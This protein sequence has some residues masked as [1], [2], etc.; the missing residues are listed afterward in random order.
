MREPSFEGAISFAQDLIRIPSPP[1]GEGEVAV[2]VKAEMEALGYAHVRVDEVGNVIGSVEGEGLAPAILVNAHLDVVAEGDPEEW[3]YPPFSGEIAG[4]C[5]HG[6]GSMDIKGQLALMTHAAASLR[7]R[8]SGQVIMAHTVLE[9]RGGWGM[10]HLLQEGSV[11]PGAV[12]IGEATHGDVT[13]G[14]RGR[15]ELEVVVRGVSGHA[16]A[17]ERARNPIDLLPPLLA[18]VGSLAERQAADPVLGRASL[19]PTGLE[20]RPESRNVIP[21]ELVLVLDWRILPNDT[22]ETLTERLRDEI[23]VA[24]GPLPDGLRIEV[25]AAREHQRTYTGLASHRS[26][27]TPGF[28]MD[29]G[30]PVVQAAAR[31]AGKKTGAGPATARPW[32]FATDGGWSCGVFGI[33]TVGFAPGEEGFAHTNRERLDL[34]EARWAYDRYPGIISAMQSALA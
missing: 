23:A 11:S 9:E 3:E 12:L 10:E 28:L 17:P 7:G 15:A 6:R 32:R 4:G 29:T 1:G 18:A 16:S 26:I 34:E 19:A 22:E 8:A 27:I 14:H 24:V 31:A 20:V 30:H 21:D 5:L 33:P 2:R 13:I 25:R